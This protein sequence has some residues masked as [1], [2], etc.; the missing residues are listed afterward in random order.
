MDDR[1]MLELAAREA[2]LAI[3]GAYPSSKTLEA[4]ASIDEVLG[5]VK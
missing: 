3:C 2:L 4:L 5:E 1:T